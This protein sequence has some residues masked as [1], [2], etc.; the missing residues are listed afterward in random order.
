MTEET[1]LTTIVDSAVA[2][3]DVDPAQV[4]LASLNS[5]HSQRTMRTALKTI[6]RILDEQIADGTLPP[7]NGWHKLT[8]QHTS[9]IR[10]RLAEKYEPA[11]VNKMLSALRGVL[12]TACN[13]G[14]MSADD[15]HRATAIKSVNGETK[16]AGREL[17][18]KE[19]RALVKA[20]QDD[21][22]PAGARDAAIIGVLYTCGLRRSELV[23]L[24]LDDYQVETG[25]IVIRRGKG[26][27]ARSVYVADGAQEALDAWIAVRGNAPGALFCAINR[28]HHLTPGHMA[29]QGVYTLVGKRAAE[30]GLKNFSPHDFR[31]SFVGD[32]LDAGADIVTVQRMAGHASPVTTSRYDRRGEEVKRK[33][34]RLLRFPFAKS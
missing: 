20:C 16:P 4:Y 25:Q 28:H 24:D 14:Q 26:N 30:A 3:P 23:A 27:K 1:A 5:R 33:A 22:T 8:Y 7:A 29:D 12:T 31:R 2:R 11:T 9:N 13:L 34:A 6:A 10:A 18:P 19:I 17:S 15:L 21:T 32:L